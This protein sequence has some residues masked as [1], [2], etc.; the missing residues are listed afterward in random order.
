MLL[1]GDEDRDVRAR[2]CFDLGQQR[3]AGRSLAAVLNDPDRHVRGLA[4]RALERVGSPSE[5]TAL[6]SSLWDVESK[7]ALTAARA[8]GRHRLQDTT[9]RLKAMTV[10]FFLGSQADLLSLAAH[11]LARLNATDAL[12][13]LLSCAVPHAIYVKALLLLDPEAALRTLDR[14]AMQLR[15][16]SWRLWLRGHALWRQDKTS[17]AARCF[18]DT[19]HKIEHLR[20][21]ALLALEENDIERANHQATWA[22]E[23]SQPDERP[24]SLVTRAIVLKRRHNLGPA[25][26]AL[27]EAR[28]LDPFVTDLQDL[29]YDHLWRRSALDD[30]EELLGELDED[31]YDV[32]VP[33]SL[34]AESARPYGSSNA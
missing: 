15:R 22:L 23:R 31:G 24:L 6:S 32:V 14:F 13:L 5:L 25:L 29:E 26:D 10:D 18:D 20:S 3:G 30:L 4:A 11:N 2:A 9:E 34:V 17:E 19:A 7:V 1:L 27:V 33:A 21:R 12:P 16:K 8:L 28:D